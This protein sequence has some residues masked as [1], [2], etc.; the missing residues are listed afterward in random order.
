MVVEF[1]SL[2]GETFGIFADLQEIHEKVPIQKF[3]PIIVSGC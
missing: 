3:L 1:K 2:K